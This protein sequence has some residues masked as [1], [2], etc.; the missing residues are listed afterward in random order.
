MTD[1]AVAAPRRGLRTTRLLMDSSLLIV[2]ILLIVMFGLANPNFVGV[3]NLVNITRQVA[4][5]GIAAVGLTFVMIAGGIDLSIGSLLGLVAVVCAA[6]MVQWSLPIIVAIMIAMFVAAASGAAVGVFVTRIG[7][8][9]LIVTLAF[10]IALRGIAFTVTDGRTI[11]GFP[12]GFS[13]LGQGNVVGVPVPVIFMAITFIVGHVV[14]SRTRFGLHV[15]ALGGSREAARLAGVNV[16]RIEMLVYMIAALLTGWAAVIQLSRLNSGNANIGMGFEFEV[17]TAVILG[18][19]SFAGGSG[20]LRGVLIG[21]LI[22]GVMSNG[23]TLVGV[24]PY[25]QSVAKGAV[26]L[27]A[28]SLDLAL[29]KKQIR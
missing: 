13:W 17:I 9:G 20:R 23:M 1:T 25:L 15:Y 3:E 5:M 14:L 18:G 19:V 27:I 11:S 16:K 8:P 21:V 2:L 10:F 6:A 4:T 24:S 28:V 29:R 7:V 12:E 26:L 22:L